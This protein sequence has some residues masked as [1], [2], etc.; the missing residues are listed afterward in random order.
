MTGRQAASSKPRLA[1]KGLAVPA[2]LADRPGLAESDGASS[3]R[4][5]AGMDPE[6]STGTSAPPPTP[7]AAPIPNPGAAPAG[8]AEAAPA[9]SLL[10][11]DFLGARGPS[12]DPA[13]LPRAEPEVRLDPPAAP[14]AA[15]L[16][17]PSAEPPAKP[18]AEAAA[19]PESGAAPVAAATSAKADTPRVDPAWRIGHDP[20]PAR[21]GRG[22]ARPALAAALVVAAILGLGWHTHRA[23]WLDFEARTPERV[24]APNE[25][26]AQEAPGATPPVAEKMAPEKT[27]GMAATSAPTPALAPAA[28]PAAAPATAPF[29]EGAEADR[30]PETT[31]P[32]IDV[33][34]VETDGAAVIAGR[35]APGAEF[36]VLHNGAP[37]GTATADAFGEW[38]FI[39]DA[40]LPA[41][42]HE[43]GLVVKRVQGGVTLPAA[44]RKGPAGGAAAP[45]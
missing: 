22:R 29:D 39:P 3:A 24:E 8:E 7:E 16:A 30:A 10:P 28:A 33:V 21:P 34:R 31:P 14:P 19:R 23:G 40:P 2:G 38:V 37:I 35:A 25:S 20:K 42:A 44:G 26:A 4:P 6:A 27:V 1:R 17:T 41:G 9:A 45:R 32:S 18:P 12:F 43:F 5:G 15:P 11:F 36:I 13:R